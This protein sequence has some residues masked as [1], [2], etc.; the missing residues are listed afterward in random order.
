MKYKTQIIS[1]V[2]IAILLTSLPNTTSAFWFFNSSKTESPVLALSDKEKESASI[3]YQLWMNSFD[4]K[5]IEKVISNSDKFIYTIP[6]L[7]SILE[8][9]SKNI[10]NPAITNAVIKNDNNILN[11]S[12]D[13]HKVINGKF[14]FDANIIPVDNKI[15]LDLSNVKLY[16]ISIP[17]KWLSNPVNKSL[18]EYFGFIY[19]DKRYQGFSFINKDNT[20]QIKLNFKK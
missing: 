3:K 11:V 16:G 7:N 5:D 10:N 8:T 19:K 4:K 6:E 20:V 12:A 2:I 17:S 9:G 13:I 18:D 15:R 1:I 14:S